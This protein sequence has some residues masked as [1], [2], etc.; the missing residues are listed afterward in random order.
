MN[1]IFYEYIQFLKDKT[2]NAD[3]LHFLKEGYYWLDHQIIKAFD[4]QG[5]IH[6]ILKINVHDDLTITLKSYKYKPFEPESWNETCIRF[7]NRLDEI[8]SK[9]IQL[10]KKYNNT[11]RTI[12]D[13][14]STGKDSMVKTYLAKKAGLVFQTY[15]N[16]TTCDVADSNKM[17]KRLNYKF[18]MPDEHHRSFYR[19]QKKENMMPSR[20]NRACCLYFKENP[21]IN[22][23][24]DKAKLLFLFGMRNDESAKRSEYTDEWKN[25]KWGSRDW[26]GILSIREW[27][28]LDIWLYIFREDI[29]INTKY[30]KGY[31]RVGCGIVCPNYNKSTWVL[32]K[33]WYPKMY[34]RWQNRL[35]DDFINN[36]KWISVHCTLKEYLQGAWTGGLFRPEPSKE[37]IQEF[38]DYKG[39][40]YEV[41]EKYFEKYCVNGCKSVRAK[42]LKIKNKDVLAMNLKLLGRNTDKFMCKK[43]LMKYLDIN[44]E[45]W[46]K[47]IE[48]FKQS[49]CKLF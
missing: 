7:S 23:F 25:D 12:I 22:N 3:E 30:K 41:A 16:V 33:Y 36:T 35:R 27:T 32:D 37:V 26:I 48:D 31:S 20:L 6:N 8:E 17:A 19:W 46:N 5:E 42:P 24:D 2:D 47:Y 13:T 15:F 4:S 29:E 21:T 43:C 14:N 34:E 9:S 39:I 45:Q 49:G 1:P 44:S 10:L 18:L 38:A 40:D 11:E 28:D